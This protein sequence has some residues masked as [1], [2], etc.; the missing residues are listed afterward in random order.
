MVPFPRLHFFLVGFAPLTS[1]ANLAYQDIN[2]V[3]DLTKSLFD[4]KNVMAACNP[5]AGKYLTAAS[6]FR[7]KISM[8][9]VDTQMLNFQNKNSTTFVEWIPNNL[10]TAVCDIPPRGLRMS[11]TFI[12]NSTSV[13]HILHRVHDQFVSMFR[14][15]AFLHWYTG[16]GM[17]EMEF[18]EAES[19]MIDLM[20][21][22]QQYQDAGVGE[23]VEENGSTYNRSGVS[24]RAITPLKKAVAPRSVPSKPAVP[25]SKSVSKPLPSKASTGGKIVQNDSAKKPTALSNSKV[26]ILSAGK[27]SQTNITKVNPKPAAA[28]SSK[29]AVASNVSLARS[30]N[31]SRPTTSTTVPS[32]GK[33][34]APSTANKLT[35]PSSPQALTSTA[36][37]AAP[38]NTAPAKASNS[39]LNNTTAS[40]SSLS[41]ATTSSSSKLATIPKPTSQT[42]AADGKAK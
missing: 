35:A 20:S 3:S 33:Q 23:E 41:K 38:S 7:G 15:K 25:V 12:G 30:T 14:R 6:I 16:E 18:T 36:K 1:R 39:P 34:T 2:S 40:T 27:G 5:N 13:Q 22:Y 42:S 26:N 19:N 31:S 28:S 11:G 37:S 9:D 17:D 32:S 10:T 24:S 21:E 29:L 4:S 8:K